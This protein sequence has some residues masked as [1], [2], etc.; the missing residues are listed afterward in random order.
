MYEV[1]GTSTTTHEDGTVVYPEAHASIRLSVIVLHVQ[2]FD[3]AIIG[4]EMSLFWGY[5][6]PLACG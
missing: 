5:Q 2:A 3:V 1:E 4:Y 6:R